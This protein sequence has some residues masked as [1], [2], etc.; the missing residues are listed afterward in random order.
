MSN[1]VRFLQAEFC[2]R[3]DHSLLLALLSDQ[4]DEISVETEQELRNTLR[5]LAGDDVHQ[6]DGTITP[7]LEIETSRSTGDVNERM[8]PP[9][10][11]RRR[12][13]DGRL[14]EDDETRED[15]SDLGSAVEVWSL[16]DDGQP[17]STSQQSHDGSRN[18]TT[19]AEESDGHMIDKQHHLQRR[20]DMPDDPLAF[21]ASVFP[22]LE[23]D[24]LEQRLAGAEGNMERLVEELLSEGFIQGLTDDEEVSAP[25]PPVDKATAAADKAARRRAKQALKASSKMSLTTPGAHHMPAPLAAAMDHKTAPTAIALA[26]S[27]SNRWASISSHAEHLSSLMHVSAARVTSTYHACSSSLPL[28]VTTLLQRLAAERPFLDLAEPHDLKMQLGTVLPTI[29]GPNLELLLCATEGDLSDAMDLQHAIEDIERTDGKLVWSELLELDSTSDPAVMLVMKD[30]SKRPVSGDWTSVSG[31]STP[32]G[33]SNSFFG[34]EERYSYRDCVAHEQ[35]Y[36]RRR[37]DAIRSAMRHYNRGGAAQRGAAYYWAEEGRIL[38][39]KRRVW[40]ERAA[41][42]LVR[43]R[44]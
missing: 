19:S 36:A 32:G 22:E 8:L 4:G 39:G 13:F 27:S 6:Y 37:E 28:T 24:T 35:D 38:D 33:S 44:R 41:K 34:G 30:K 23:L 11:R 29:P 20:G 5:T 3:L 14:H 21:L 42:A 25:A 18:S 7:E 43:E 12:Q 31:R 2:P 1:F 40:S 9:A 15:V 26:P 10:T 16:N 17:S